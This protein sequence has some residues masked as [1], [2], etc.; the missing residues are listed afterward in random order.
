M[1]PETETAA[2][3]RWGRASQENGMLPSGAFEPAKY[4]RDETLRTP[5]G[6]HLLLGTS[7]LGTFGATQHLQ[8]LGEENVHRSLGCCLRDQGLG[9]AAERGDP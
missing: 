2:V 9:I 6:G 5:F 1:W 8:N 3:F 7:C 4:R